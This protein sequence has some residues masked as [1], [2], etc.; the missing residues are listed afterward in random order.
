[1]IRYLNEAG[2]KYCVVG[3]LGVLIHAYLSGNDSLA[4]RATH[5]AD[6]MFADDFTNIDF[7][8]AWP[9]KTSSW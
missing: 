3:G 9:R 6:L 1:M 5:D 7:S 4:L 2:V 8:R